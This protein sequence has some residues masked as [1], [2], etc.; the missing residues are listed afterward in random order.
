MVQTFFAVVTAA[1]AAAIFSHDFA[2]SLVERMATKH[3]LHPEYNVVDTFTR[4]VL[5]DPHTLIRMET[6][7]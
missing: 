2:D 6:V 4:L 1:L 5:S 3:G 7:Q